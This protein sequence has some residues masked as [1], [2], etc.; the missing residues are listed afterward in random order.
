MA[1]IQPNGD[2]KLLKNCPLDNTYD[3]TIYFSSATA[4]YNYFVS[5]TK[6]SFADV[7]YVKPQNRVRLEVLAD[8]IYDCNYIMFRNTNFGNKWFYAFIT[9]IEYINNI[10]SEITFEID[11]MQTWFFD[12]DL[13]RCYVEREHSSTDVIGDNIVPEN[14]N[15][16]EYVFNDY[17][18]IM[19]VLAYGVIMAVVDNA[20]NTQGKTY[21]GVYGGATLFYFSA[22]D[23]TGINAKIDEYIN[24]GKGDSVI[25]LYMCPRAILPDNIQSGTEIPSSSRGGE[26]L[27]SKFPLSGN[28]SLDGYV[29]KNKKMYTY[30]Y[31]FLHV[32]N[33]IGNSLSLRY[34]FFNQHAPRVRIE[35]CIT[36]P[37]SMVL[38]P[39]QYK[40]AVSTGV[41]DVDDMPMNESLE[42]SNFPLCSWGIDSYQAWIAQNSTPIVIG[43]LAS[44]AASGLLTSALTANP[45][46][47]VGTGLS[48]A[49]R[50]GNLASQGYQASISADTVKGSVSSGSVGVSNQRV[51][52]YWGRSSVNANNARVID[53]YFTM[54]GYAV[55]RLKVPN[56]NVRS[57][58]TYVKTLGCVVK[59]SVPANDMNKICRIYDNGIT[60]WVNGSEVG[61]YALDNTL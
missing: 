22:A 58:W 10:T 12:Y 11:V 31:N 28:E 2:V 48:L 8:D 51:G 38:R 25:G 17:N 57:H 29:P 42:I 49:N 1:Y 18:S 60:F 46:A 59:G 7:S 44:S 26:I 37:V 34:E 14:V 21:D 54:Y 32:D 41:T 16:G 6:K 9:N 43:G 39:Q 27:R 20:G 50:I 40:G 24:D 33:G 3:H 4:Q 56:R 36:Q 15:V 47:L 35:S 13:Q 45:M 61:N 55:H 53:D 5:L 23:A 52:F 30:P 19:G